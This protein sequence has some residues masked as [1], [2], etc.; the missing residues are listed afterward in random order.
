MSITGYDARGSRRTAR[1]ALP[2]LVLSMS[3]LH[4]GRSAN[5]EPAAAPMPEPQPMTA[6][7]ANTSTANEG[8]LE[9]ASRVRGASEA[10]PESG[11][12]AAGSTAAQMKLSDAEIAAVN[13]AANAAEVEQATEAKAKAKDARVRKFAQMMIDHHGQARKDQTKLLKQLQLTPADSALST[14]MRTDAATTLATLKAAPREDFDLAYIESQVEVHRKVLE[15]LDRQLLPNAQSAELKKML[16][17]FRPRI[18]AHLQQATEIR[19][20]FADKTRDNKAGARTDAP[21]S[22]NTATMPS[23]A[24]GSTDAPKRGSKGTEKAP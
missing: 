12:D 8:Q 20:S 10:V 14:Q 7:P 11:A 13:D 17:D 1:L 3:L 5:E 22:V 21:A 15:T 6:A 9:P 16:Q 2:T 23:T 4:C 24:P 19:Q 18:E